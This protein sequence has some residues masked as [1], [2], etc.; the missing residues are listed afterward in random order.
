[1]NRYVLYR[2]VKLKK[3]NFWVMISSFIKGTIFLTIIYMFFICGLVFENSKDQEI[4]I[5]SNKPEDLISV[6]TSG[7]LI[8]ILSGFQKLFFA[9]GWLLLIVYTLYLIVYFS[10][11]YM[12]DKENIKIKK[13]NGGNGL[14]IAMEFTLEQVFE[15]PFTILA[16][17]FIASFIVRSVISTIRNFWLFNGLT[18]EQ[19]NVVS[20]EIVS[21]IVLFIIMLVTVVWL[22]TYRKI[23]KLH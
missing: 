21:S 11:M 12:I 7:E 13:L 16:A 6:D 17:I 4:L 14:E 8:S 20:Y 1:M 22:T 19:L 5:N 2:V 18:V 10:K 15:I 9:L 23:L 3:N